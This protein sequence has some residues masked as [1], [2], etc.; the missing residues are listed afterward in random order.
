MAACVPHLLPSLDDSGYSSEVYKVA[1]LISS[2][3]H[4]YKQRTSQEQDLERRCPL[5]ILSVS[6]S[7]NANVSLIVL[8]EWPQCI[9]N[10]SLIDVLVTTVDTLCSARMA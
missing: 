5:P 4:S 3:V 9:S 1:R 2:L 6:K 8:L 10:C 7:M